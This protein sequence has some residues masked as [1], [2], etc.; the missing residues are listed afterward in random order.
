[1]KSILKLVVSSWMLWIS[2][3]LSAQAISTYTNET[4]DEWIQEQEAEVSDLKKDNNAMISWANDTKSPTDLVFVYLHG[5][6]ASR[7]EAEP[8]VSK[9]AEEFE[10]NVFYARLKGHG[11]SG[12]EGFE[13]LTKENYLQ[14]AEEALEIGRLLGDKVVLIST[15]TG[16]TLSLYLASKY[17]DIAGLVLYSP[18]VGL[19]NPMMSQITTPQ[20]REMFKSMIGGEV[21]KMDRSEPESNYWSTEYHINA[22]VALIGMLKETMTP[23]TFN[24]VTAPVFMAYYYKSEEEQDQVV[25]VSAMLEMYDQLGTSEELKLKQAFPET[26]NHVI[27]SELRS[28]DWES[29]LEASQNFIQEKIK[30]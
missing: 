4:I 16:G 20:G 15:S 6:G 13:Q 7:M 10:A 12:V 23:D 25:S 14:S 11:R 5:F 27:A 21:Q 17:E 26:G 2:P 18:F 19:K 30:K 24:A 1:M 9:L 29:V 8:V 3:Q 22:Y 28:Q